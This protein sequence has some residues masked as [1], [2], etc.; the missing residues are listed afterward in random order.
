MCHDL[1]H[2][3]EFLII[4]NVHV[5]YLPS[6][7]ILMSGFD[8]HEIIRALRELSEDKNQGQRKANNPSVLPPLNSEI[9]LNSRAW[10]WMCSNSV[11]AVGAGSPQD[12]SVLGCSSD[13]GQDHHYPTAPTPND[14]THV[15]EQYFEI[16]SNNATKRKTLLTFALL[17]FAS[18]HLWTFWFQFTL[19][20]I[21]IFFHLCT[22][23]PLGPPRP[24]LV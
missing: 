12:F 1:R 5:W 13:T 6:Y 16:K 15:V 11:T 9:C 22:V 21:L 19:N 18:W 14:S 20:A 24:S 7:Y 3:K 17:C 4:K 10:L 8:L 23:W 2:T